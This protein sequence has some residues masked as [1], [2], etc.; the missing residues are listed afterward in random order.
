MSGDQPRLSGRNSYFGLR[1]YAAPDA[2][3]PTEQVP[4]HL[5]Q[6]DSIRGDNRESP[7][8]RASML[9]YRHLTASSRAGQSS[10]EPQEVLPPFSPLR[11][12]HRQVPLFRVAYVWRARRRANVGDTP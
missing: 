7:V 6:P 1:P 9:S 2:P 5:L 12:V 8:M 4:R 11:T 3:P 10:T